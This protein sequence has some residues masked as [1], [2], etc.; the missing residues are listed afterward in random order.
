[1][2]ARFLGALEALREPPE[3][4]WQ[5]LM[6][7]HLRALAVELDRIGRINATE[8]RDRV[9]PELTVYM[10]LKAAEAICDPDAA[11]AAAPE[12]PR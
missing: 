7:A 2:R 5:A 3:E 4:D 12:P 8:Q 11:R 1:M 6:Q 10:W 9:V